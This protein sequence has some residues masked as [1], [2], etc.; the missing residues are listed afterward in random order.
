M[1]TLILTYFITILPLFISVPT[2][3]ISSTPSDSPAVGEELQLVCTVNAG[4]LEAR[5]IK[6]NSACSFQWT[7]AYFP[8]RDGPRIEALHTSPN[9]AESDPKNADSSTEDKGNSDAS[10]H[11]KKTG[12][13][14]GTPGVVIYVVTGPDKVPFKSIL[15]VFEMREAM[16]GAFR[17]SLFCPGSH[18][19]IAHQSKQIRIS[20]GK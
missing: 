17:C 15:R 4:A 2:I 16:E 5:G 9:H 13:S 12:G 1:T 10:E 18:K 11:E 14:S 6:L 20:E 7:H 19:P 3:G 8:A